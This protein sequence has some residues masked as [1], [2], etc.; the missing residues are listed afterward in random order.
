MG[1]VKG[2]SQIEGFKII[3]EIRDT[4]YI[5]ISKVWHNL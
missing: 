3:R 2:Q 4:Y 1:K 5:Y